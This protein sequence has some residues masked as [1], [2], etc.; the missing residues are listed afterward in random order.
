MSCRFE[1]SN[2]AIELSPLSS[3]RIIIH[4]RSSH[5]PHEYGLTGASNQ[6]LPCSCLTPVALH[7][8]TIL[9]FNSMLL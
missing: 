6:D 8:L 2:L 1:P 7:F 5:S 3:L 9:H 4:E